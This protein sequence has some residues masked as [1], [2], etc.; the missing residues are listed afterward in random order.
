MWTVL[1]AFNLNF[2]FLRNRVHQKSLEIGLWYISYIWE[3]S[4]K[5]EFFKWKDLVIDFFL[6]IWRSGFFFRLWLVLKMYLLPEMMTKC[7]I[8]C[9]QMIELVSSA[10]K[11]YNGS[12]LISNWCKHMSFPFLWALFYQVS[13][14]LLWQIW[15]WILQLAFFFDPNENCLV[16]CL[17][18]CCSDS[19]P[20]R[21]KWTCSS[22]ALVLS[23]LLR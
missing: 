12:V 3:A 20:P 11:E 22:Y 10:M 18:S 15:I 17:K 1:T 21:Y 13:S 8:I 4:K 2:F 16:E 6:N 9:W 7:I 19:S 23:L 14:V 5:I